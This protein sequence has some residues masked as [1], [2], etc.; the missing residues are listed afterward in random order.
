MTEARARW[1]CFAAAAVLAALGSFG[2]VG[3]AMQDQILGVVTSAIALASAVVPIIAHRRVGIA[4]VDGGVLAA[5]DPGMTPP[6]DDV[7]E[8]DPG[9]NPPADDEPEDEPRHAEVIPDGEGVATN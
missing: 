1:S 3:A 4:G 5:A 8:S 7:D 9:M 2:V 6:A